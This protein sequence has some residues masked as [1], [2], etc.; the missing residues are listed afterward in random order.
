MEYTDL[1]KQ[2]VIPSTVKTRGFPDQFFMNDDDCYWAKVFRREALQY[3][4]VGKEI[5]CKYKKVRVD[6]KTVK[7][8]RDAVDA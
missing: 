2:E 4:K 5:L 1:K 8:V 6:S 7:L 3:D